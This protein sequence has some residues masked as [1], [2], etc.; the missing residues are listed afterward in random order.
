MIDKSHILAEIRRT[1]AE[2]GGAALGVKRFFSETGI[3]ESDWKGKHWA[4]WG[5]AL[6]DADLSPNSLQSAYDED[7]LLEKFASLAKELG[8]FP[9]VAELRM[10]S[11]SEN[12]F[13]NQATFRERLGSKQELASKLAQFCKGRAGYE[14]VLS[15]C[16]TLLSQTTTT[17]VQHEQ[18]S[19][20]EVF[21][22]VYLL[23]SG[24][25]YKV[26]RSNSVGRRERELAIQLPEKAV[27]V[28]AIK[29][30]DP[31]GIELYWHRRFEGKRQNGEWFDLSAQDVTAFRRRKFM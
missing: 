22:E 6:Q 31:P 18:S 27:L 13:P 25:F 3:K 15:I 19:S 23:K 24:R 14:G 10:K 11:R 29:T 16:E 30:D 1:A 2:N 28:H 8:R 7:F 20:G 21:G 5:D 17:V 4:R 12:G 9:V 26:G